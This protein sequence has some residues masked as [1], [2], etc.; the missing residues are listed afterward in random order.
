[1][2]ALR[3]ILWCMDAFGLPR[4][5]IGL[6]RAWLRASPKDAAAARSLLSRVIA[7]EP[8]NP[9]L[10]LYQSALMEPERA[11]LGEPYVHTFHDVTLETG[12]C[13]VFEDGK[14]YFSEIGGR[15]FFNHPWVDG[16]SLFR[17]GLY[18]VA[19]PAPVADVDESFV[20]LG[21]DGGAN[22]AHWLSRHVLKLAVIDK[23]GVPD[24]HRLLLNEDLKPYQL[25]YLELLGIPR[26]RLM[27]V[28][29]RSVLR[30]RHVIVPT[31]MRNHPRMR[32]AIDWLRGRLARFMSPPAAARDLVF[33]SRKDSP[34]R[35]LLNEAELESALAALGF[36]TVVLGELSVAEQIRCF[37]R[38]AVIVGAHGAGLSNLMFAPAHACVVE[39]TSSRIRRM[40]DFRFISAQ[41]GLRHTEVASGWY[42]ENQRAAADDP[43]RHDYYAHVGDVLAAVR[44]IAPDRV[45]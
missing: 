16:R 34:H 38:A 6:L 17:F 7:A 42:P 13:A 10:R 22:Y 41:M 8:G 30:C 45:A 26:S 15:N 33:V 25:E 27:P 1:M 43:Q 23:A 18:A 35:V 4:L 3:P 24:S 2:R 32:Q 5:A 44:E 19:C 12:H 20:L 36:R 40:D 28:P 37:S 9:P 39:I 31:I 11:R 29:G 21:T 14:V